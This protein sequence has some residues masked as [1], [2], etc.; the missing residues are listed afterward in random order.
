MEDCGRSSTRLYLGMVCI[1][2]LLIMTACGG[3]GSLPVPLA[4]TVT[5]ADP[6]SYVAAPITADFPWNTERADYGE[7]QLVQAFKTDASHATLIWSYPPFGSF[8]AFNGDGGETYEVRPDGSTYITS[9]QDGGKPGITYFGSGWWAFDQYVPDCSQGWRN[10][11][12]GLGR[13]CHQV[14]TYPGTPNQITV[15]TVVSEHYAL[16]GQ[17]GPMERAFYGQGWGRL[18]WMAFNQPS[19]TAVNP[20]RAPAISAFDTGPGPAKCD[21]RLNTNIV[22]PAVPLSGAAFGWPP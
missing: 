20:S 21:E 16:P 9:T 19:C 8:V 3:G 10:G 14:I 7:Y 1:F 13:A 18:A 5:I 15:D 6:L 22:A 2:A 17:I 11:P 4:S 12:D